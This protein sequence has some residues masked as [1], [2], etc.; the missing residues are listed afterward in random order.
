M[1]RVFIYLSHD[2]PNIIFDGMYEV[3]LKIKIYF[4]REL[5]LCGLKERTTEHEILLDDKLRTCLKVLK[6]SY[7]TF[8]NNFE[9]K[10]RNQHKV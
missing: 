8:S 6:N 3:Q 9:M 10:K 1:A 5:V 4:A 7:K 2:N